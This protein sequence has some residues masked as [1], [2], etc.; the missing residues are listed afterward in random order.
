MPMFDAFISSGLELRITGQQS[1]VEDTKVF[2]RDFGT[3]IKKIKEYWKSI[4]SGWQYWIFI[5]FYEYLTEKLKY[6]DVTCLI[7]KLL[8]W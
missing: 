5:A 8:A 7:L 1:A 2:W 4:S 3:I 6:R